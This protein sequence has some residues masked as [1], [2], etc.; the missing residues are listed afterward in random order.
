MKARIISDKVVDFVLTRNN[1][2][3]ADL[4]V[5]DVAQE[6][7]LN[8]SHLSRTFRS[9]KN[10]TI[11]EFIFRTKISRAVVMMRSYPKL[12]IREIAEHMGFCR[13]DYFIRIFRQQFGITPGRYRE[14]MHDNVRALSND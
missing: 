3:L 13:S 12:S 1:L 14:V 2:Q 6:I 8:R 7:K 9:Q 10:L 4:T 5:E 11:E